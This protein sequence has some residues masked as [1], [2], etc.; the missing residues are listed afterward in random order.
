MCPTVGLCGGFRCRFGRFLG[1]RNAAVCRLFCG[2]QRI[3]LCLF[4]DSE[5]F[6]IFLG[7]GAV[8]ILAALG[9]SVT[10]SC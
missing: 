9:L 3:P 1:G 7:A 8:A 6:G 4:L 10:A 5:L 2:F